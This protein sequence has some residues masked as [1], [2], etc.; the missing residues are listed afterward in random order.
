MQRR[1]QFVEDKEKYLR[2]EICRIGRL[3]FDRM[4]VAGT[5]GNISAR[6]SDDVI[7]V[8]PTQVSKGMISPEM[9]TKVDLFGNVIS[10]GLNPS[11]ELPM[12][13]RIYTKRPDVHAVVHAHPPFATAH[14]VTGISFDLAFLPE[15]VVYLGEIPIAPYGL[16]SSNE[17]PDAI[18]PYLA[19]HTALLLENHGALTWGKDLLTAYYH[20]ENLEQMAK[21][22]VY[23]RILGDIKYLSQK[24]VDELIRIKNEL[25]SKNKP[26]KGLPCPD[27]KDI[28]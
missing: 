7:L 9:I 18:E 21:I 26:P 1:K 24:R 16:P 15:S 20:M 11:S 27:G 17:I 2:E 14:A 19:D 23:G 12:H 8:T 4:F 3:L 25:G 6:L 28:C 10:G 22:H 5:E 13:L